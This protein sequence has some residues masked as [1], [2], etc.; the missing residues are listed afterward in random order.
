MNY[1]LHQLQIFLKVVELKSITKASEELFLSQPA[2]SMQLKKFQDQFS[3]PL[4]EVLG[5]QLYVTDFG[6]EIAEAAERILNEVE[7]INYKTRSRQGE[8]AGKLKLSIVSTAKYVMPFFLRDF[9]KYNRG[10]DI[11]MDV[12]NKAGVIKNLERN[13]VD[14][15]LVSAI[16]EHLDLEFIELME[17]RLYLVGGKQAKEDAERLG[18]TLFD[19]YPL[20]YR[21]HGSATRNAMETFIKANNFPTH[22]ELEIVSNEALKQAVIADLGLS[23]MPLIGIKHELANNELYII[24]HKH[25]PIV[26]HWKLIWLSSK[27][28]SP[29]ASAYLDFINTEKENIMER[30]FSWFQN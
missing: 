16:P 4:T 1:T 13:K 21:E 15:A 17:N 20:I 28:F 6:H 30:H 26:T 2:V 25:L 3:I 11:T 9:L 19:T 12:T 5:R 22:K 24:E 10:V 27:N 29:I 8:L 23:V 14:F 7:A 18:D